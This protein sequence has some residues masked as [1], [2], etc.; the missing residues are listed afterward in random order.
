MTIITLG[1][2]DRVGAWA[3]NPTEQSRAK[4][5]R[6]DLCLRSDADKLYTTAGCTRNGT[7]SQVL[8]VPIFWKT[9]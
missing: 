3:A 7:K 8:A 9:G 5:R 6:A 4:N 2:T 1:Y